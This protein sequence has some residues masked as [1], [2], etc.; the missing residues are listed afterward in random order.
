MAGS[1]V[2]LDNFVAEAKFRNRW[3]FVVF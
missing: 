3:C 2:I 1:S